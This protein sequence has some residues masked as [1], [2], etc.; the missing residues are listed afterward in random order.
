MLVEYYRQRFLHPECFFLDLRRGTGVV[1]WPSL[2]SVC[3][4]QLFRLLQSLA[5]YLESLDL[6]ARYLT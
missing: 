2:F 3:L 5:V 6:P 1:Q 4:P